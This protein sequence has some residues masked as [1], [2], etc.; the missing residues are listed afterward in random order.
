MTTAPSPASAG[1][2]AP[3]LNISVNDGRTTAAPGDTLHYTV[4]VRN[5]G[6]GD[7]RGL[8]ITQT[9]PSGATVGSADGKGAVESGTVR[10]KADLKSAASIT[11]HTTMTLR[12]PS[13]DLLRLATVACAAVSAKAAPLVCASHSD[14]L[15]A[16]ARA[17]SSAPSASRTP[18]T[19]S[20]VAAPPGQAAPATAP[21]KASAPTAG[22]SQ[23]TWWLIGGGAVVVVA[24]VGWLMLA[25]RRK[26]RA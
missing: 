21:G 10:W 19:S 7:A 1:H 13:S 2:A 25:R 17:Q 5:I 6:S 18:A 20:T 24:A 15:P 9:V 14:L 3:Q 22:R 8:V 16:G 23:A 12:N 26:R 11:L 4:T